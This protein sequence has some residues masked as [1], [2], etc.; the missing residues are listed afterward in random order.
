MSL[1]ADQVINLV[2]PASVSIRSNRGRDCNDCKHKGTQ[3]FPKTSYCFAKVVNPMH[4]ICE[5][6]RP[7]GTVDVR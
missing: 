2:S 3:K 6:F 5:W 4:K 7:L 1:T